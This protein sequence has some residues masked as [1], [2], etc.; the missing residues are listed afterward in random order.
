M[1]Q[2]HAVA[3][4][5]LAGEVERQ[6]KALRNAQVGP[7]AVMCG[8]VLFGPIASLVI[9]SLLVWRALAMPVEYVTL[10]TEGNECI[11][12]VHHHMLGP[13]Y[14]GPDGA[15]IFSDF[16]PASSD[17]RRFAAQDLVPRRSGSDRFRRQCWLV[18]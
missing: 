12:R 5:E 8:L 7:A 10:P 13:V 17:V 9:C 18:C 1:V 15:R 6:A 11:F 2:R 16:V 3:A 4:S 14:F